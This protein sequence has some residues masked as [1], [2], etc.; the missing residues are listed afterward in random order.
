MRI[1]IADAS[2]VQRQR[3]AERLSAEVVGAE[4]VGEAKDA[5]QACALIRELRPDVVILDVLMPKGTGMDVVTEM[6][7]MEPRPIAIVLTNYR[8]PAVRTK[9]IDL[10]AA[11]FFDKTTE[12]QQMLAVLKHLSQDESAG[13]KSHASPQGGHREQALRNRCRTWF[14]AYQRVRV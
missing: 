14:D 9:C 13:R 1:L 11:F 2:I 4:V 7:A 6:R 10:G 3:L 12:A 8:D 5:S